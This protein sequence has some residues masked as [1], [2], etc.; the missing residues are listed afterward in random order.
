MD[1][2][3]DLRDKIGTFKKKFELKEELHQLPR[4][5][6]P[7]GTFTGPPDALVSRNNQEELLSLEQEAAPIGLAIPLDPALLEPT[8]QDDDGLQSPE[9]TPDVTS[10]FSAQFEANLPDELRGWLGTRHP[11]VRIVAPDTPPPSFPPPFAPPPGTC[12]PRTI[13][14]S[15]G[16]AELY[17]HGMPVSSSEEGNAAIE[18]QNYFENN[19]YD[20]SE[21]YHELDSHHDSNDSDDFNNGPESNDHH[22]S[23]D[24]DNFNNY[25]QWDNYHDMNDF[26]QYLS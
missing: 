17:D 20:D 11:G 2:I 19:P 8:G 3:D 15:P 22:D 12:D 7:P 18:V 5:S 13:M 26:L 1:I 25:P 10:W 16:E 6:M 21:I 9:Y 4:E 24:I 23:N 14:N